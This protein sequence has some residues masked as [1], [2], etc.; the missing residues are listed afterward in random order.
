ME[1]AAIV[2]GEDNRREYFQVD[3]EA[4]RRL[5]DESMVALMPRDVADHM[6]A[7][8][9][10]ELP[11]WGQLDH[12]CSGEPFAD[13]PAAAFCS[14][15]L[16][17]SDLVLTASHCAELYPLDELRII[18]GYYYAANGQLALSADDVYAASAVLDTGRSAV[19]PPERTG[20]DYAWLRLAQPARAPHRPAAVYTRA[21]ALEAGAP[22]I[23]V[24]A[25]GGAPMKLDAGGRVATAHVPEA[26]TDAFVASTD[27]SGGSSG[28]GAFSPGLGLLGTLARGA[29]DY[30]VDPS[31]CATT[32]RELDAS[33]AS[34]IYV[35][36]PAAVD[37][38]C[39]AGG[40]SH[41]CDQTCP[42]PCR[43]VRPEVGEGCQL[44]RGGEAPR[45]AVPLLLFFLVGM[46]FRQRRQAD[47]TYR[48]AFSVLQR[49]SV[50]NRHFTKQALPS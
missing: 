50:T 43:T 24:S 7:G 48:R 33:E 5:I 9:I 20:E 1:Y 17:D 37:G 12:L 4:Q 41:L 14:G 27:T 26:A 39:A 13:Q 3:Q 8:N 23:A 36:A 21:R 38:L 31:G 29:P 42:E 34:E 49:P 44:A 10:D 30:A 18:F 45:C 15:V 32:R 25:G 6:L 2:Y 28:G 46:A 35:Y 47:E 11:T 22:L 40:T 16:A 19:A